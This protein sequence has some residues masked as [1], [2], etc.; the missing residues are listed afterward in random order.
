MINA[1]IVGIPLDL[2]AEN[3]GV[4]IGPNAIRY[5][6][7]TEKLENSGFKISD[8]GNI[9]CTS[10]ELLS[11]GSPKLK[12]LDEILRVSELAAK[13][14]C[15][16]VNKKQKII[17]L[18]GDH[19]IC[20]GTV[21][22]ASAALQNDPGLIYLDAHGDINTDRTS[23][24][25]NIHGM[26]LASLMG[27]GNQRL[28]QVF[29]KSTKIKKNNLLHIG[30]YDLDSGE[31]ELIK[32]EKLNTF[33]IIDILSNGLAPLFLK[34]DKLNTNVK[35]VWVSLDLDVIDSTYAPGAGMPNKAGLTYREITTICD[36][37]GKNSHVI[38]IDVV[39]YNP[40]QDLAQ[41]IVGIQTI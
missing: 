14:I 41:I 1:T 24:T 18:G 36:Y 26:H 12:Y 23:V 27:F 6:N 30:G 20:L 16:L 33:K 21:S 5:Q 37:V 9:S 15:D 13:I 3:L 4:D 10:R 29:N 34:I 40:L 17:A 31:V 38:G 32:N 2:G 11:I 22:G 8:V 35:D 19:S 25:G 7:I 28:V 39:E